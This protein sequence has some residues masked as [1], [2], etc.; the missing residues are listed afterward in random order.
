MAI[1]FPEN[2]DTKSGNRAVARILKE[3]EDVSSPTNQD[4]TL[5]EMSREERFA[6]IQGKVKNTARFRMTFE[7]FGDDQKEVFVDEYLR[8]VK[9]VDSMTEIEEQ[10]LFAAILE[11]ILGFQALSRKEFEE[12]CY[13]KSMKGEY[14]DGDPQFRRFVD[15]KYAKEYEGHMKLYQAGIKGLKMSRE[16]RL[17]E[18]RTERRTLVD[19]AQE[20]SSKNVQAEVAENIE[21]LSRLRDDELRKMIE[22][23]HL[24]G[25]FED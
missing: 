3:A 7:N 4:K 20:L 23:G 24:H 12:V 14:V 22:N 16:Q 1:S 18:I 6:Y 19:L 8:I 21:H 17:K 25:I 9:S 10:A 5:D 11:L 2:W 15:D 13:E